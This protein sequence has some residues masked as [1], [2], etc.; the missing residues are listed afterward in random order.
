MY[1]EKANQFQPCIWNTF[2]HLL[3]LLMY[4]YLFIMWDMEQLQWNWNVL[5]SEIVLHEIRILKSE[6]YNDS[7]YIGCMHVSLDTVQ[8]HTILTILFMLLASRN[9]NNSNVRASKKKWLY[10]CNWNWNAWLKVGCQ[11]RQRKKLGSIMHSDRVLAWLIFFS[12]CTYATHFVCLTNARAM[13][14]ISW[15]IYVLW[16]MNQRENV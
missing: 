2:V 15:N 1:A 3:Y 11:Q 13:H 10:G 14:C 12:L 5:K 16:E 9:R 6:Y 4:I 8:L 7:I